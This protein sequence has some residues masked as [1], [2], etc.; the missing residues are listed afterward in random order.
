MGC[1]FPLFVHFSK[2]LEQDIY[3]ELKKVYA[4]LTA[5]ED[6]QVA[7]FF[8][9]REELISFDECEPNSLVEF[10]DCVNIQQQQSIKYY[11]VRGRH[12]NIFCVYLN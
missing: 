10:E 3:Q 7:Y 12:K 4:K 11:F 5:D 9:S 2:T 8:C 6:T 1:T